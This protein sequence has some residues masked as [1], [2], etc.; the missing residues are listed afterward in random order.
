MMT[1]FNL[2]KCHCLYCGKNWIPR[3]ANP[4]YCP[5]CHA[6]VGQKRKRKIRRRNRR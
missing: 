1:N 5:K 2:P 6:P 4:Q 3:V